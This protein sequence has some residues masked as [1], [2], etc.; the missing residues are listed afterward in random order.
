ML[1]YPRMAHRVEAQ[2]ER[3]RKIDAVLRTLL[4]LRARDASRELIDL[5]LEILKIRARLVQEP[6]ASD[7][8]P[9]L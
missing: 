1:K 8:T 9:A 4:D 3:L 6:H 7:R 2:G 5:E